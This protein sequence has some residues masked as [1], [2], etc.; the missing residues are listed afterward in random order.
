MPPEKIDPEKLTTDQCLGLILASVQSIETQNS[1]VVW[2][3]L[4]IIAA[5]IGVKILGSDPLLD[6]A[7]AFGL[8]GCV[9][10]IGA[11]RVAVQWQRRSAWQLTTTGFWLT[12]MMGF[13]MVTQLAVYLRDIDILEP[14]VI[15]IIRIAQNISI[16]TFAW[17]LMKEGQIW[18]RKKSE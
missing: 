1:R 8:I 3:L 13:I 11:I 5:Q 10:V 9:L 15:Y 6:I 18:R 2:A 7:T 4:G 14:R 12:V 16:T 17:C